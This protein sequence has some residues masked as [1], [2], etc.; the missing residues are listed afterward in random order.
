M[1]YKESESQKLVKEDV[2][3]KFKR[4]SLKSGSGEKVKDKKQA[5]A[6]A[7]SE[8]G[9][10]KDQTPAQN[11]RNLKRALEKKVKEGKSYH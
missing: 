5:E 7:L 9:S 10:S 2:M 6:I 1:P 4:G 3:S 8:S 11:E